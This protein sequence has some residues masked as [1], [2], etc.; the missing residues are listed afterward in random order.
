VNFG[1][2]VEVFGLD[3]GFSDSE[4]CLVRNFI[5]ATDIFSDELI[6]ECGMLPK[7]IAS[8]M[9]SLG[10][11]KYKDTIYADS[12]RP[13]AIAEI[14]SYGYNIKPADKPAG[15]V[16]DGI[17]M[18]NSLR[19]HWTAR[20]MNCIKEQRNHRFEQDMNGKYLR[21]PIKGWDN[22]LDARRY[23]VY[24]TRKDELK[25]GKVETYERES[26]ARR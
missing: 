26:F 6:Y 15:S 9:E 2:G 18:V 21:K 8:R 3:F 23:D 4:T 12:A 17:D 5:T 16:E 25:G 1:N 20:S 19:Q 22:G 7:N 11:E 14:A 13:E 24:M 10:I